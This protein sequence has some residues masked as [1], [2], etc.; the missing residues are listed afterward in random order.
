MCS[1]FHIDVIRIVSHTLFKLENII[2][3]NRG[4]APLTYHLFQS[5]VASI[6]PPA[7]AEPTLTMELLANA[8]TPVLDDHDDKYA[9][10]TLEELGRSL[11]SPVSLFN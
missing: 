2:E 8:Y 1:E 4:R 9:V 7:P 3:L 10:P 5:I 6:D 11:C